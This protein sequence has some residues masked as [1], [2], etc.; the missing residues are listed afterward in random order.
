MDKKNE[1]KEFVRLN[2]EFISSE[3]NRI[4][5]INAKHNPIEI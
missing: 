5:Q 3:Q 1:Q 4:K 2:P